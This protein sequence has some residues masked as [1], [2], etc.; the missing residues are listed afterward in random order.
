MFNHNDLQRRKLPVALDGAQFL[1][2]RTDTVVDG[3]T[4]T[5]YIGLAIPGSTEEAAV[6]MI[7]RVSMPADGSS[8][9]LFA[10]GQALFNQIWADRIS[11]SYT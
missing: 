11:L 7:Q 2:S 8:T 6:W 3:T 1:T 5:I 10:S 4:Q 9:T